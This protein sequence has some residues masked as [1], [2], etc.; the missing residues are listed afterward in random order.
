MGL[1]T[2]SQEARHRVVSFALQTAHTACWVA[3]GF[4]QWRGGMNIGMTPAGNLFYTHSPQEMDQSSITQ[5]A[6]WCRFSRCICWDS[7]PKS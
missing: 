2:A 5:S 3:S 4:E 7:V 1:R 6:D